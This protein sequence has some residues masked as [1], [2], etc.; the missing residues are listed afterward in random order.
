MSGEAPQGGKAY[1]GKER[2]GND[3]LSQEKR[4]VHI[5]GP[6]LRRREAPGATVEGGN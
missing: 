1:F 3:P 5:P 6:L 4:H 2:S